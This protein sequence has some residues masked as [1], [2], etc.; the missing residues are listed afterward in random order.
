VF[1]LTSLIVFFLCGFVGKKALV[2]M[3]LSVTKPNQEG[4][5]HVFDIKEFKVSRKCYNI[6]TIEAP[7]KAMLTKVRCY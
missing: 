5:C 3:T 6:K 7:D 2:S 4:T 1:K